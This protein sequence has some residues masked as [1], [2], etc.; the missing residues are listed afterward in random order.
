MVSS[1][2]LPAVFLDRDGVLCR[3]F[4]RKSKPYAPKRLEDFKLMPY[5]Y[6]SVL[7]LKQ[8]G[9]IVIVVTNQPDIGNHFVKPDVVEA[10]HQKLRDKALVDDIFMCPHSQTEGC[11]CR[12]PKS[13]MLYKASKKYR[14]DL[15]K[16]FIVGD[17]SSDVTAG[18]N[19][20]CRTIFINRGYAEPKPL[21]PDATVRS[22]KMAVDFI[23]ENIN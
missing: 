21:N 10:M 22:L 16:S 5:S 7:R 13:G 9:F 6:Q 11:E 23:L 4:V 15:K 2:L 19:A 1:K 14:I 20:G 3:T 8:H 17:R 12:K 18:N